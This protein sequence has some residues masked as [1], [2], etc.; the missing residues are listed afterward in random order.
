MKM[1]IVGKET[2][3]GFPVGGAVSGSLAIR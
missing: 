1:L 2:A 3:V